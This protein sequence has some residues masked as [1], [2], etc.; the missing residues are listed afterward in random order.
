MVSLRAAPR[1]ALELTAGQGGIAAAG[2]VA[3]ASVMLCG[4]ILTA[5][6]P[7]ADFCSTSHPP[8]QA[9]IPAAPAP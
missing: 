9:G 7:A 4:W 1:Q 3:F 5:P 6:D 2:A 8:V